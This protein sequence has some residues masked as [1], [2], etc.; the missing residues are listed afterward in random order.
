MTA[1]EAALRRIVGDLAAEAQRFALVE[2]LAVSTRTEPRFTRVVDVAVAVAGD[3]AAER[4]VRA[5]LARGY[6][7]VATIEHA[8]THRLATARLRSPSAPHDELVVDLLFA[9][10]GVEP[11]IVRRAETLELLEGLAVPVAAL[12][13][14]LA[15]RLLSRDD[16]TRPQ[17]GAD[18]LALRAAATADDLSLARATIGLVTARGCARGRDLD[19]A[20]R[21]L[22]AAG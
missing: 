5:L 22:A 4:L 14:L 10:S 16:A 11:E 17:D 20:W 9:S 3:A 2:G 6:A 7:L 12:G 1:V 18:L 13:D 21:A 19:A 15:L 8:A